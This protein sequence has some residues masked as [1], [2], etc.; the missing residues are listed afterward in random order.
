LTFYLALKALK[1]LAVMTYVSGSVG[2]AISRNP[3]DRK[4]HAHFLAIPGFGMVWAFGVLLT[5][6]SAVSVF[7]LWIVGTMLCSIISVNGVLYLA[8][9]DQRGGLLPALVVL[10]PLIACVLLM[11]LKP[12]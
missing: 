8:G 2:T 10:V 5:W 3:E 4:R 11:T 6:Q 1:L 9:K 12:A 7:S